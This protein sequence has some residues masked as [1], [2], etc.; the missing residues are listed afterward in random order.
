[1]KGMEK[2]LDSNTRDDH[3]AAVACVFFLCEGPF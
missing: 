1:M 2:T 3:L